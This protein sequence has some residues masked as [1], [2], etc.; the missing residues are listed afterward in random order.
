M[1][2]IL[3]W[4]CASG[5]PLESSHWPERHS[6]TN[7]QI[8]TKILRLGRQIR[9]KM[10]VIPSWIVILPS[11]HNSVESGYSLTRLINHV[12]TPTAVGSRHLLNPVLLPASTFQSSSRAAFRLP[13]VFYKS[14]LSCII[15]ILIEK[16]NSRAKALYWGGGGSW[17]E[18]L[19]S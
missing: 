2:T 19:L 13:F 7:H 9:T 17:W 15:Y 6:P 12:Q 14:I 5:F 18:K 8:K 4:K 16:K 10:W 11:H 1:I 3:M